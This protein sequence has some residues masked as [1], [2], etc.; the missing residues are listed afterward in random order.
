LKLKIFIITI[1]S[2]AAI[3]FVPY[4]RN[5][6]NPAAVAEPDWDVPATRSTFFKLC[7]DCHS[8]ETVWPLYSSIA[9]VSW[10]VQRDVDA[11]R[12]HFN[13]SM[14]NIQKENEG[15][16]AAEEYGE[17]DMPPWLYRLPRP[18]IKLTPAQRV[19]FIK[20]LEDT[21]GREKQRRG[22]RGRD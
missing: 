22:R 9:P 15:H 20:G 2:F 13:V 11:G 6:T 16:K 10:L 21:F 1:L 5:H 8:H 17:G 3:Q 12:G 18:E 19:A 14:W 7:G 4:G